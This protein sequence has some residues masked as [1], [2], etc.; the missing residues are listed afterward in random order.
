MNAIITQSRPRLFAAGFK[1]LLLAVGLLLGVAGVGVAQGQQPQDALIVTKEGNVG[2]GTTTPVSKLHI[3]GD[4]SN[5]G[6]G[7][8]ALD[9][10]DNN[11]PEQYVLR[12]NPFSVGNSKVG[13]QF[14]T[15]SIVGGTQ[16]P[17]T[18]DNEGRVGIGTPT[19]GVALEVS[20]NKAIRVGNANLSSGGDFV[21]LANHTWF[22]GSGWQSSGTAG[23]LYQ[24]SGMVHNW[25]QHDGKGVFLNVMNIN[26]DGNV[27]IATNPRFGKLQVA[28]GGTPALRLDAN[29]GVAAMSIGGTG[30][31]IVDAPGVTGG[32]FIV[33]DNG[34]VGIGTANPTKAKLEISGAANYNIGRYGYLNKEG[35]TGTW[36][37]GDLPYSLWASNDVAAPEFHTHSD[38]RIKN[39]QGRSDSATDLRTLLNLEITNYR[40][41]DVIARGNGAYKKITGQQVEKVFP[42]AVSKN[43]EVVPDIYQ[44][45]SIQDGWIALATDLK[46]GE[47]V[48]L[49]TPNGEE[50]VHE[51]LEVAPGKFRTDFKSE[52]NMVFVYGREVNDFLTVD[53]GAISMLNV[54]ATQQIKKEKDEEVKA[55]QRENTGLRSQL[56]A[57]EKRLAEL[58]AKDKTRGDRL[59]AIEMLL[60]STNKPV[61]RTASLKK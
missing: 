52:G 30:Q 2:V 39:I 5:K 18:F 29:A 3:H 49:I 27:G 59:A 26:A 7:G 25:Y 22:N 6:A 12:I 8:L 19:P 11:S 21:N 54:S 14:Q 55:L 16:L 43:T 32:R 31:L 61:V 33:K 46:K 53:Y 4:Y 23:G 44:A 57:Q 47:R 36:T 20:Q 1:R 37:A 28:G 15:K 10:S 9:A 41:K 13:Y 38:A 42:Q 40:Y 60:F 45:A 24:I 48:K 51:I 34:N 58:E 35:R 50:G 56:A 17:L